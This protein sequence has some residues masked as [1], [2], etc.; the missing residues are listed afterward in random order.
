MQRIPWVELSTGLLEDTANRSEYQPGSGDSHP[1]N[2]QERVLLT[3]PAGEDDAVTIIVRD[4]DSLEPQT[5]LGNN[6]IDFYIK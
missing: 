6:I 2:D 5:F 4:R 1:G 3:F